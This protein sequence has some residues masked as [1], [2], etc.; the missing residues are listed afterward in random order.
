[1]P[2]VTK[3]AKAT[4]GAAA[5]ETISA[6]DIAD[7]LARAA[8]ESCRQ[9]ERLHRVMTNGSPEIELEGI[10]GIASA[11]DR[12]VKALVTA[13]EAAP[14]AE[15]PDDA[16][17]RAASALWHASREFVRRFEESDLAQ[18]ELK[19]HSAQKL[20]ELHTEFELEASAQ[21]ALRHAV[22]AYRKLRPDP[23]A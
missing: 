1:M 9:H 2:P 7:A 12:H 13:Y 15:F 8:A 17:R 5:P 16:Q 10:A 14:A 22:S 3:A 21:L 11:C 6:A 18:R 23:A 4:K 19:K 20:T